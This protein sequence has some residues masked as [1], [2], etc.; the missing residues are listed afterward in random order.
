LDAN[1]IKNKRFILRR[2]KMSDAESIVKYAN[3]K[4]VAKNLARL[5]HPYTIGDARAWLKKKQ[6]QYKQ[7]NPTEFVF[8]IEIENEA[9]GS[10]GFNNITVGHKAEMG[11]WIGRKYWGKGLMTEVVK[12]ASRYAFKVF[13]LRRLQTYTYP[14][15]KASKRVL[16]KNNFK[17]EGVLKKGIRKEDMFFDAHI[18]AKVS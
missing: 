9:V 8:A 18:F 3:D 16:E 14:S 11:Y 5:P 6:N 7:K 1:T 17:F 4:L 12:N 2:L 13:K 15:N 10:I